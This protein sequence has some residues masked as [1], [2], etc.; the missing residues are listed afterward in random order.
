MSSP[1]RLADLTNIVQ[2]KEVD[3]EDF[4]KLFTDQIKLYFDLNKAAYK[5][6]FICLYMYQKEIGGDTV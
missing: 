4:I 6:F 3:T 2:K 1:V 5:A